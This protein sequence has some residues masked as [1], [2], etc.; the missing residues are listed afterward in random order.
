MSNQIISRRS[1]IKWIGITGGYVTLTPYSSWGGPKNSEKLSSDN[2]FKK[3]GPIDYQ[4]SINEKKSFYGDMP[5]LK[6]HPLLW[7]KESVLSKYKKNTVYENADLV[8][9]GGGMSGLVSAY[10]LRGHKPIILEQG[11]RFGGNSQGEVW[12]DIAYSVGAAYFMEQSP[13]SEI[14]KIFK[15]VGV[16]SVCRER[17][18][19]DQKLL[20]G[21]FYKDFWS[22]ETDK[23]HKKQFIKLS[24]FFKQIHEETNGRVY[25]EIPLAVKL[26]SDDPK[27]TEYLKSLDKY[28]FKDYLEKVVLD[29]EKL[30][31]HIE[32]SLERYM[33]SAFSCSTNEISAAIGLNAYAA[34][35]GKAYVAPAGNAKV[36]E[37]FFTKSLEEI[38]QKN[39]R[40]ESLVVDVRVEKDR[41]WVTY[42]DSAGKLKTIK[43][44][45]VIMACPKFVVKRILHDIEPER[46][47]ALNKLSYR[48]YLVANVLINKKI[49]Q[50]IYDVYL[51][52]KDLKP[53]ES[54]V[55]DII[56]A[57]YANKNK[58]DS[59]VLTLYRSFP[60][61]SGRRLLYDENSFDKYK[62]EIETQ[63]HEEI[64]PAFNLKKEN[65]QDLKITRWGH[66]LP[67]PVAGLIADGT[68][69]K[70]R[71]P[72]KEKVFFIEQDNWMMAAL[73]SS[74]GEAIFWSKQVKMLLK[75]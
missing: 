67:L 58:S 59:T 8:I 57:N 55:S 17:D 13:S 12:N 37:M 71:K 47:L 41:T 7:E 40:T 27:R 26:F 10:L 65:I 33:W 20:N 48:S 61:E 49:T 2:F 74:V 25:P 53:E 19:E 45:A 38:P 1:F 44:K 66:P 73:E 11:P 50:D 54:Q 32:Q 23:A 68:I 31:P 24:E 15:E 70:I 28:N 5:Q 46:M 29:G 34:E 63:L 39:Y 52:G 18:T 62:K 36:A 9:I 30:I 43:A 6:A 56:V 60:Y 69:E 51:I 4:I 22:G 64:L 3:N 72:F 16:H 21:V 35:F 42:S 14:F 75:K